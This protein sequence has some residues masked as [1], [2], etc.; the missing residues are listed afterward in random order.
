[1]SSFNDFL[2]NVERGRLG[3]NEGISINIPNLDNDLSILPSTYYLLGA[4][5]ST[6]KTSLVDTMILNALDNV[7]QGRTKK[8][9]KIFYFSFEIDEGRKIAKWCAMHIWKKYGIITSYKDILGRTKNRLSD[10]LYNKVIES[11]VYFEKV[12]GESVIFYDK[13]LPPT[14]IYSKV[15]D[16]CIKAGTIKETTK[17]YPNNPTVYTSKKYIANDSDEIVLSIKDHVGYIKKEV[18][19]KD[20]KDILDRNSKYNVSLRNSYGVSSID[21]CQFNRSLA[22]VQRQKFKELM[23][24]PAD[25]KN[26]GD[27]YED[28]DTAIGLFNPMIHGIKKYADY[29]IIKY[30]KRLRFVNIMKNRDGE[31]NTRSALNFLGEA[32]FYRNMPRPDQLATNPMYQEKAVKFLK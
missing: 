23:P 32:G 16:Y 9:L 10:D 5:S 6:G 24:S 28:A 21:I 25:F 8:S 30:G 11:R 14:S 20:T 27:M 18:G 29:D 12:I 4:E 31:D 2:D 3:L 15:R 22:D 19:T 26:S 17:T 7:V 1:M 13:A